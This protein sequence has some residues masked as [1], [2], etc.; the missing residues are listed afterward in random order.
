MKL[1]RFAV[2]IGLACVFALSAAPPDEYTDADTLLTEIDDDIDNW[3]TLGRAADDTERKDLKLEMGDRLDRFSNAI[4]EELAPIDGGPSVGDFQ[5]PLIYRAIRTLDEAASV[6]PADP[7]LGSSVAAAYIAVAEVQGHPSYPNLGYIQ[8]SALTYAKATRILARIRRQ[9]PQHGR[10]RMLASQ[11]RTSI[12]AYSGYPWYEPE[13]FMLIDL[14]DK[15]PGAPIY[16]DGTSEINYGGAVKETR[17]SGEL[18]Q[19]VEQVVQAEGQEILAAFADQPASGAGIDLQAVRTRHGSIERKAEKI[20]TSAEELHD[21][22]AS[23]GGLRK[24]AV[25]YLARLQIFME[26]ATAALEASDAGRAKANLVRAEYEIARL[27][28]IVGVRP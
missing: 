4:G 19:L 26:E 8:E 20:W 9:A 17:Q 22:L 14:G 16:E 25:R 28:K 10:S 2:A 11:A 13:V 1:L 27:G 24:E 5:R 12:Y 3:K 18:G 23:E 21:S 7:E 15:E 6:D